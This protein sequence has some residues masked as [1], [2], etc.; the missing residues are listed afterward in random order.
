MPTEEEKRP[1][2]DQLLERI[3]D[4]NRGKLVVFLGPA[5]GVGKTYAMLEAAHERLEADGVDV[6]VGWVETHKRQETEALLKGLEIIPPREISYKGKVIQEMDLDAIL[7]RRPQLA[8][9]DELAHTNAPGS[10]HAKRYQ[11]VEELLD[12][13]ID[14]FTTLNI[15]HLESLNDVIAQI[16]GITVKET[17]PDGVLERA[18]EIRLIDLS[19]EDLIQRL[20]EG[21]VYVPEQAERALRH[22]FRPGN[23]NALRELA[24]RHTAERV[25]RQLE[26]YMKAHEIKGPWPV[27]ERVLVCVSPS[28]FSANLIRVAYRMAVRLRADWIAVHVEQ[29]GRGDLSER[30]RDRLARNLRLAEQLGAE[31]VTLT[32]NDVAQVLAQFARSRNVTQM[33]IGKP[34]KP[35]LVDLVRGSL[36]DR[37]MRLS[38]GISIHVIPGEPEKD[39]TRWRRAPRTAWPGLP[40]LL[41]VQ[42]FLAVAVVTVFTLLFRPALT[43]VDLNLIY[44]LPVLVAASRLGLGS[45]IFAAVLGLL[46]LDF[47]FTQPIFTFTVANVRHVFTLL[48]FLIVAIIISS[49]A[50]RLHYEARAARLREAKTAALYRLSREIA[51]TSD[52]DQLVNL[53]AKE[54]CDIFTGDA[55]VILPDDNG[56]LA[57]RSLVSCP[58]PPSQATEAKTEPEPHKFDEKE[59]ATATWVFHHGE[60]AGRGTETLAEASA[61]YVPLHTAR[62]VVGV[63]GLRRNDD[64]RYL[65]PDE[66]RMLEAF[67]GLAAVAIERIRLTEEAKKAEILTATEQLRMALLD[68]V[69]HDLR[70][71]LASIIGA[72]TSLLEDGDLYAKEVRRS[73][74]EIIR[75]EAEHMN[76][77][78]GN[79]L[80]MARLETGVLHLARDWC[81]VEDVIGAALARLGN[82][83]EGRSVNLDIPHDLPLIYIDFVLIEQALVNLLD[84]AVRY[85][86]PGSDIDIVVRKEDKAIEMAILD[87]GVGIPKEDLERIFDKFYRVK[88]PGHGGGTGLG[89]SIC[90]GI[91]HAHGGRIWAENREGGGTKVTFTLPLGDKTPEPVQVENKTTQSVR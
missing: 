84:N 54:A 11:D 49:F 32:G 39:D 68:S 46:A 3:K 90:K 33:I 19:P 31:V 76:R 35:M 43:T 86:P 75:D 67:A 5:A 36:V 28:P 34:L 88:R 65:S 14:V 27:D 9:V 18:D 12:A 51:A 89:L 40:L 47:F 71:P 80:D 26:R 55:M 6:V 24:L 50:S 7:R 74:L 30:E 53:V 57:I 78:V 41:Y 44:L 85:S 66:R 21:K 8:L 13:G 56:E 83:L 58:Q 87:R 70:T 64:R 81:D 15:Q 69:S 82:R 91:V 61:I 59:R 10:R 63:L 45:A 4:E 1:D 62:R 42:A 77:L 17:I 29:T 2:P 20:K 37:I 22:F 38:R 73:F 79:L 48:I 25:D 52:A 16:T 23:I 72:V 60:I